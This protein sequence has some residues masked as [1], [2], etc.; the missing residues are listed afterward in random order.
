MSR[1]KRHSKILELISTVDIETQ[2]ELTDYLKREGF[3]VTQAT[4][5]RD[6]KELELVKAASDRGYKYV[7]SNDRAPRIS[8]RH[9]TLFKGAVIGVDCAENIIVV[10]TVGGSANAAAALIDSL[11][12]PLILGSVAGDDTVFIVVKEKNRAA[13]VMERLNA[14]M[15]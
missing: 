4:V 9:I 11:K 10:K 8:P 5:S 7:Q 2:D 3:D 13:E 1:L 6:I 15:L 12:D 14:Y